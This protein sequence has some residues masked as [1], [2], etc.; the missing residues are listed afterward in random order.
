MPTK[1]KKKCDICSRPMLT[2][3]EY[4]A[5]TKGYCEFCSVALLRG[6]VAGYKEGHKDG[7]FVEAI[8]DETKRT[9]SRN[10][11]RKR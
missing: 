10:R 5:G 3:I 1:G 9:E 6:Y 4:G 2:A 7:S 11:R 8:K